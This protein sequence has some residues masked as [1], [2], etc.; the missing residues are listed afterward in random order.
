[1]ICE[2][3]CHVDLSNKLSIYSTYMLNKIRDAILSYAQKYKV[4]KSQTLHLVMFIKMVF[5]ASALIVVRRKENLQNE[6][7]WKTLTL[8]YIFLIYLHVV[9]C[10]KGIAKLCPYEI[11]IKECSSFYYI[12]VIP[13]LNFCKKNLQSHSWLKSICRLPRRWHRQE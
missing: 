11:T 6:F 1:M 9:I 4:A 13:K 8:T 5:S 10:T 12:T 2:T 3:K 7:K